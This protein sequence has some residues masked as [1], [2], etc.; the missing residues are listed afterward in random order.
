MM[1]NNFL[2][3]GFG[4]YN[5]M[6]MVEQSLIQS[7][8]RAIKVRYGEELFLEE[9]EARTAN[10]WIKHHDNKFENRKKNNNGILA[11]TQF[12]FMLEPYTFSFL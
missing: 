10:K 1:V 12:V 3:D 6:A 7:A 9:N 8:S 11:D 5:P 2:G 4:I